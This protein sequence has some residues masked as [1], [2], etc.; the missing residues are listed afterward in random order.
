MEHT[1][2]R[3]RFI[4]WLIEYAGAIPCSVYIAEQDVWH[5][6]NPWSAKRFESQEKAEAYMVKRGIWHGTLEYQVTPRHW[7]AVEHTFGD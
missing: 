1:V 3:G 5:T 4:V 7:R 2:N 6:C